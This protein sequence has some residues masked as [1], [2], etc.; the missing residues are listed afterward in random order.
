MADE[1][2]ANETFS[3]RPPK[4]ACTLAMVTH[5][6][7]FCGLTMIP[8]ANVI[9]PLVLWLVKKDEH[10]FIDDQ[11]KE[12]LNFQI[13]SMIAI[14]PLGLLSLI[15]LVFCITIPLIMLLGIVVFVFIVMA[16]IKANEGVA[17]RYPISIR[18]IK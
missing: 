2:S 15:P 13:T 8:F 3:D 11:G 5:L 12:S 17:Y 1:A 14:A 4:S 10:P 9:G 16:A 6:M 7:A 18:F